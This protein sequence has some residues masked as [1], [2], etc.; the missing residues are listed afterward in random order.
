[1]RI[2][3]LAVIALVLAAF[4]PCRADVPP[5]RPTVVALIIG[6]GSSHDF[7]RWWKKA[8]AKTL[9]DSK[10]KFLFSVAYT[11]SAAD[12][13]AWI[14]DTGVPL[15]AVN[16]KDF[17]SPEVKAALE[18]RVSAG[19]GMVLLHAG[20]WYNYKDWPEYNAAYVGG[21]AR[22]HDKLGEFEVTVIAPDHPLM[23]GVPGK[24]K[25]TD[26]LYHVVPDPNGTPIEVLATATNPLTGKTFPSV[27]IVKHPK[28][29]IACIA[30][31]H[32]G[33][34]HEL[35]AYQTLLINA[36]TWAAEK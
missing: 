19:K 35:P 36:A 15:L 29:K 8:D 12:A 9:A 11:D 16:K 6:G 18:G 14:A 4:T 27:W 5:K 33:G 30:L 2:V 25:I 17:S 20:T 28:A 22:G 26:E 1:M 32:D 23:K 7:N 13:A 24:F 10:G 21:G 3:K 31:G 34:A